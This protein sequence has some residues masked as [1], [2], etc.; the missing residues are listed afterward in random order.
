M[1]F[2]IEPL[3]ANHDREAFDCREPSLNDFLKLY[4]RQNDKKGLGK[5][6]VAVAPDEKDKIGGYYTIASGALDV[7]NLPENLPRYPIPV[8]HIGRLAVDETLK[9][10]GLGSFLLLDALRRSIK[11]AEQIGIYAV[12]VRALTEQAKK[13]YLKFGFAELIDNPF[14]LYLTMKKIRK[15]D[16]V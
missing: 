10:T 16:L 7:E 5:T 14:H 9:G 1:K 12:E 11:T 2:I 15:L 13:F 6:F 4:A 3:S 8:M